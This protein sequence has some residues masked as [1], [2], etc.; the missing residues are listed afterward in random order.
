M[1]RVWEDRDI[2]S[3]GGQGR[4]ES[5]ISQHVEYVKTRDGRWTEGGQTWGEDG[6][7]ERTAW[8]QDSVPV[9]LLSV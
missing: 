8:L 3:L 2:Q 1:S 7:G 6:L 4:P 9:L 5:G